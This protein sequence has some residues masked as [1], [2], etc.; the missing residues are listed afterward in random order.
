V[1]FRGGYSGE[2]ER[3]LAG[4]LRFCSGL[5]AAGSTCRLRDGGKRPA[6]DKVGKLTI[7]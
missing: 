6:S 5:D 7:C 2:A 3:L 1:P 4:G